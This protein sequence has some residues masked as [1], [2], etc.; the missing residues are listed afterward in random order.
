MKS[1]ITREMNLLTKQKETH[2]LQN[3]LMVP[4][5]EKWEGRD[6]LRGWDAHTYSTLYKI[7][8]HQGPIA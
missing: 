6:K 4:K 8:H 2:K 3:K 5:G 7:G 1:K